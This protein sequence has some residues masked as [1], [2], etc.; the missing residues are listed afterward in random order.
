MHTQEKQLANKKRGI[1][2]LQEAAKLGTRKTALE[3]GI[4]FDRDADWCVFVS[5]ELV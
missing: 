3:V 2:E 4:N 1:Q 5:R